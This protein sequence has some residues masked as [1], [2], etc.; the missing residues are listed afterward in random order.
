LI[1]ADLQIRSRCRCHLFFDGIAAYYTVASKG[2]S[3]K[4]ST[5][6]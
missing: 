3:K 2:N 5:F 6:Q 4:N 1:G